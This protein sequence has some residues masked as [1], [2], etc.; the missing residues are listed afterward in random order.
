[1][2]HSVEIEEVIEELSRCDW[3][4]EK[5]LYNGIPPEAGTQ[6][7]YERLKQ[8]HVRAKQRILDLLEDGRKDLLTLILYQIEEIKQ[9]GYDV[10]AESY[11]SR[12]QADM[13]ISN[14]KC[15]SNKQVEIQLRSGRLCS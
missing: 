8:K 15:A 9:R 5:V 10:P 14:M 7:Y 2:E 6:V 12:L 1:M 11:L 13:K 3:C 4:E